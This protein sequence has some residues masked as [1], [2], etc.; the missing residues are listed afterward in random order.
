MI[1]QR[2]RIPA[3]MMLLAL[4]AFSIG[5]IFARRGTAGGVPDSQL[6]ALKAAVAKPDVKWETWLKYGQ[7]LQAAKQHKDAAVAYEQVLKIDPYQSD[8]RR[9][10]A[11]C[12]AILGD[13]DAFLRFMRETTDLAPKLAK[14]IFEQPYVSVYLADARFEVVRKDAIAGSMD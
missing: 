2:S 7:A 8:A 14:A 5:M 13:K 6:A 12:K 3:L 4:M 10:G 11:F 1:Q 9:G